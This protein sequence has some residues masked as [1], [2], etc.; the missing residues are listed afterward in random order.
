M[1][2]FLRAGKGYGKAEEEESR[3]GLGKPCGQVLQLE[4]VEFSRQ[5]DGMSQGLEARKGARLRD[6]V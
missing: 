1:F 4:L 2:F 3:S 6:V 5:R